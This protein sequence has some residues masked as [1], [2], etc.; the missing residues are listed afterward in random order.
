M[1]LAKKY[2]H[3]LQRTDSP[4][5]IVPCISLEDAKQ[6]AETRWEIAPYTDKPSYDICDRSGKV[7]ASVDRR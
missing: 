1:K 4:E 2:S 7:V 5:K 3:Y 6:R